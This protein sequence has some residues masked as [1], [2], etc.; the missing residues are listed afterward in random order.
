M[1]YIVTLAVAL[2]LAVV[3]AP[4]G[5]AGIPLLSGNFNIPHGWWDQ[6]NSDGAYTPW[7]VDE[8]DVEGEVEISP[9]LGIDICGD[10]GEGNVVVGGATVIVI[11]SYRY[12]DGSGGAIA[13]NVEG[14]CVV[15]A[16]EWNYEYC[17]GDPWPYGY[18]Q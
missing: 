4:S 10:H 18:G 11:L 14:F 6:P 15:A 13:S 8:W 12:P 16:D 2:V 5:S 1:R 3:A 9:C 17:L 7:H